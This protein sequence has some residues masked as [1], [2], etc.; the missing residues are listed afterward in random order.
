[1]LGFRKLLATAHFHRTHTEL[2]SSADFY[3]I[4]ETTLRDKRVGSEEE[5]EGLGCH[6]GQGQCMA[7]LVIWHTRHFPGEQTHCVVFLLLFF[8]KD[9][10]V[11]QGYRPTGL[12]CIVFAFNHGNLWK[13]YNVY[14][15]NI[16]RGQ[17]TETQE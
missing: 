1:M 3:L 16:N 11:T 6:L 12:Y 17:R 5:H 4:V 10:P 7:G 13:C 9:R 8:A 15:K 14:K 2:S